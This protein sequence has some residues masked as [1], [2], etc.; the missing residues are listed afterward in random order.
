MFL[1]PTETMMWAEC[2]HV[3]CGAPT[4]PL[5]FWGVCD[6]RTHSCGS[7]GLSGEQAALQ[8]REAA[9]V[10]TWQQRLVLC[11]CWRFPGIHITFTFNKHRHSGE[12]NDTWE[13]RKTPSVFT[14]SQDY[15]NYRQKASCC[16][17]ASME[18]ELL[19]STSIKTG[20]KAYNQAQNMP[21]IPLVCQAKLVPF[22]VRK[23]AKITRHRLIACKSALVT[24][25]VPVL[26]FPNNLLNASQKNEIIYH[27]WK[28]NVREEG[29]RC[30][31]EK[32][33]KE[34]EKKTT[35]KRPSPDTEDKSRTYPPLPSSG[36]NEGIN[37][38]S[39]P[40]E[41][42]RRGAAGLQRETAAGKRDDFLD[43]EV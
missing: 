1:A 32:G 11:S 26:H 22:T 40:T 18:T 20:T 5:Q 16:V 24:K 35:K 8:T 10:C 9:P 7:R 23:K 41:R 39:G 27:S 15:S 30:V 12:D 13:D 6:S 31:Q 3:F 25:S 34:K 38:S 19:W 14:L 36:T 43:K 33:W 4:A 37:Q 29:L 17:A 42:G 28:Q 21:R 2:H